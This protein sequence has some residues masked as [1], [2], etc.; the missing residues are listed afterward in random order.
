MC[1]SDRGHLDAADSEV[2]GELVDHWRTRLTE[3]ESA[4]AR[5]SARIR[6]RDQRILLLE[7]ALART[8]ALHHSLE[9]RL[10]QRLEQCSG[11]FHYVC[12]S[13]QARPV[14]PGRSDH[15][16]T[17]RL[18]HLTRTLSLLFEVM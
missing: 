17:V 14:V 4:V 8:V 6:G 7:R 3:A 2:P 5:L 1:Q 13:E 9:D 16:V 18:P 10:E 15:G 12:E 11:E